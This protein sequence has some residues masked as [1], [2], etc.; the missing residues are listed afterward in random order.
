MPSSPTVLAMIAPRAGPSDEG[1]PRRTLDVPVDAGQ[2]IGVVGQEGAERR[3][4]GE[5]RH[6]NQT[7]EEGRHYQCG[8]GVCENHSERHRDEH[9]LSSN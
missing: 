3:D 7:E 5:H 2:T 8:K 4:G 6:A 9:D 1:G